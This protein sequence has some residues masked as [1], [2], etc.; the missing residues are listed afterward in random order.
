MTTSRSRSNPAA[1]EAIIRRWV[2]AAPDRDAGHAAVDAS[3]L[4]DATQIAQL[5]ATLGHG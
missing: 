4:L 2:R 1:I 5:R 3:A